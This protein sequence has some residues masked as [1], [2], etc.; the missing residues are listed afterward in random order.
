MTSLRHGKF[1]PVPDA[2]ATGRA[3][4]F[5]SRPQ[6]GF[7]WFVGAGPGD[8]DLIT[9]RG[10]RALQQADL[11]LFDSLVDAR[12]LE[13]LSAE[14]VYVGKRCGRHSMTQD[15]I[16]QLLV[17][18]ARA[19]RR[20]VRL[21]GGDPSVLGR[22]GEEALQL[23]AHD[24]PFDLIPGVTSATAV[25][26]LAGI[27]ITHRGLADSFVVATAHRRASDLGLSIP[28][29]NAET[30]LVLLMAFATA[31][32]WHAALVAGGYPADLPV[33]L[34]SAGCTPD[35]RV[36]VTTVANALVDLREAEL[37][38]PVLAVVGRVVELHHKLGR[39][40]EPQETRANVGA[41]EAANA[42]DGTPN[43]PEGAYVPFGFPGD[44]RSAARQLRETPRCQRISP[45]PREYKQKGNTPCGIESLS[46]PVI[47]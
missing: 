24:L 43:S 46:R 44:D 8:P 32:T 30:T 7:V 34:V 9:L 31:D 39:T 28:H 35:Q 26:M 27:P 42:H 4:A 17:D 45:L 41:L 19:G 11:V 10:W 3:R 13:E 22:V 29:Y 6:T 15:E 21:K 23:A 16:N 12:L 2:P 37:A 38:T 33:A 40:R 20:V 5:A 36:V 1:A 25:P 47:Q 14:C 18:S